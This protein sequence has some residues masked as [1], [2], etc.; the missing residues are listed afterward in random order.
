MIDRAS[1]LVSGHIPHLWTSHGKDIALIIL[2][3]QPILAL[4]FALDFIRKQ[5][6]KANY[7]TVKHLNYNNGTINS[8]RH[9][10]LQ[11]HR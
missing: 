8:H 5:H 2:W 9:D 4:Y 10:V 3:Y 1:C 11:Y 6:H 7:Q